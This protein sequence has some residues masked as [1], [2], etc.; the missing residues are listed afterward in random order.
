MSEVWRALV[1]SDVRTDQGSPDPSLRGR[2][3]A[4]SFERVWAVA[5][6]VADGGLRG[7]KVVRSDDVRGLLE[8]EAQSSITKRIS[9]VRIKVG[10][11]SNGQTRVDAQA[12][13]RKSAV[14]LGGNRRRVKRFMAA[15]DQQLGA[16]PTQILLERRRLARSVDHD[17][18]EHAIA[19]SQR[20]R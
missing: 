9:D 14:E 4:I 20:R 7:W 17:T 11:D 16:N 19:V 8:A 15:L 10:L 6:A 5:L 13:E 3:Y 2:T 12:S 1:G 18:I